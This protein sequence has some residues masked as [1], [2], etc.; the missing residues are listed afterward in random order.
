MTITQRH[1]NQSCSAIGATVTSDP[2]AIPQ[3]AA[4]KPSNSNWKNW[5]GNLR[6]APHVKQRIILSTR[7]YEKAAE[8]NI[9][10]HVLALIGC[11]ITIR[12]ENSVY[13]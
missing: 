5:S 11:D 3:R 1:Q 13:K 8:G 2:D 7:L 9:E 4:S 10:E 6:V 12:P